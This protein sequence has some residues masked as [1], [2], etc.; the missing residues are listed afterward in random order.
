MIKE[1]NS[2]TNMEEYP[3]QLEEDVGISTMKSRKGQ[4][5]VRAGM[6]RGEP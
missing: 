4:I 6:N 1:E 5:M 3:A 2:Y